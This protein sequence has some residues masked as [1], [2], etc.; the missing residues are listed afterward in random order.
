MSQTSN[1]VTKQILSFF[2]FV[3]VS[4]LFTTPDVQ[5]IPAFA[6]KYAVNCTVC[7]VR[8]P[9]LNQFGQRFLENGYQLPGAEDGGII[10]KLK[11]GDL[12][13]D[14]VSNYLGALFQTTAVQHVSLKRKVSG[15][16]EKTEV[17]TPKVFRLFTAGTITKNVGFFVEVES[18]LNETELGRA[19]V[20]LNNLGS[21]NWGHLRIGKI[22][23]SAFAS[24]STHRQHFGPIPG[25]V[26]SN[27]SFMAPTINRIALTPAAFSSKFFGLFNR[28]GSPALPPAPSLYNAIAENGIDIHG[29]PF[30][31]WFLYQVGVLNGAGERAGDSNNSKDWFVMTRFDF[32]KSAY[33]SA[34]LSGFAYFGN[35]NAKVA[36]R[37]DVSRSRYGFLGNLRYKMVDLYG[38]FVVD[39]VSDLPDALEPLFD[40]TA[41]GITLEAN[42]LATDRL[43]LGLRYDHIDAGG[44]RT[45]RT[46]SSTLALMAK[47]YLRSNM[48]I[49]ARDD[50]NL[51]K[52]HG[53]ASPVR[54][55]RNVF[56][57][58]I[59]M[60]F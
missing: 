41:T 30:G 6:R 35:H 28:S 5:A 18:T 10:G 1:I 24:Y 43:M 29:R 23:P 15:T 54:N 7:H 46:N 3:L 36:T 57:T 47:Y 16:D 58:G 48:A 38:A 40:A 20:T 22:D 14:Q 11:Y 34:N 19:F 55:F 51:R 32:A 33:F 50:I 42:V 45:Q 27:G 60:A 12:T 56:T 53:G 44:I 49:F 9:R 39:R 37:T 13:L 31:D 8:A 4:Q 52:A 26:V 2:C 21:H 17:G 59:F 25:A